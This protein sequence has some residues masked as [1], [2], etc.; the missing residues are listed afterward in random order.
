MLAGVYFHFICS[1][2]FLILVL[3][4][5]YVTFCYVCLFTIRWKYLLG[6]IILWYVHTYRYEKNYGD[7]AWL[8]TDGFDSIDMDSERKRENWKRRVVL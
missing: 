7:Y 8:R 2:P 1:F 6:M 4:A 5:S 3:Y